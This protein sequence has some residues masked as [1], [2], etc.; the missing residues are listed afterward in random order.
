MR[1]RYAISLWN[2]THYTRVPNLE[3]V[4][5]EIRRQG[6]G[7][8]LWGFSH[9]ETDLFDEAGRR[10]V[11][12]LLEGMTVS[13]H[14]RAGRE[15]AMHRKQI[16]AAQDFAAEGIVL[17]PANLCAESDHDALD[18]ELTRRIVDYAAERNVKLI[19]ENG[20]LDFLLQAVEKVP[21]LGICIDTGHVYNQGSTLREYL[22]HLKHRLMH[23]HLQDIVPPADK[24]LPLAYEDHYRPGTGGIPAADW[25]HLADTLKEID[26]D[27][28]AVFE[29]RPPGPFQLAPGAEAYFESV[30]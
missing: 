25:K 9:D 18:M 13:L 26:F 30:L 28:V 6:Y 22:K 3:R 15:V 8:E 29:V 11:K 10:R 5:P 20:K 4:I 17:H 7:V 2:F 23:L 1:I 27:G 16:D 24:G 19:L 12:P 14:T 21:E